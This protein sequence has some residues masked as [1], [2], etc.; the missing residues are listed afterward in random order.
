MKGSK[1]RVKKDKHPSFLPLSIFFLFFCSVVYELPIPKIDVSEKVMYN[2]PFENE[3]MNFCQKYGVEEELALAIIQVESNFNQYAKSSKNAIGLMQLQEDFAIRWK[4]KKDYF[5]IK[6]NLDAGIHWIAYLSSKCNNNYSCIAKHYL[7]GETL[8]DRL[9]N[10]TKAIDYSI[11]V[12]ENIL[13]F[14]KKKVI[15]K[16]YKIKED[17]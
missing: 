16:N 12:M 5:D 1:T 6:N 7:L 15:I 2:V 10:S 14:K 8:Y 11:K 9:K 3:I 17:I 4:G 13:K